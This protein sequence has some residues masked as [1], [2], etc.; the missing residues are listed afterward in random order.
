MFA[1]AIKCALRRRAVRAWWLSL[2]V[3][4]AGCDG[5]NAG[6]GGTASGGAGESVES[7]ALDGPFVEGAR[8][9]FSEVRSIRHPFGDVSGVAVGGDGD[10]YVGDRQAHVVWQFDSTG[11][12]VDSIGAEGDGP[13]D[14]QCISSVQ[15]VGNRL[16]VFD[17]CL[18]RLTSFDGN[19]PG[20]IR[21]T[22]FRTPQ[23]PNFA[24]IGGN[25]QV[26]A[27]A[28]AAY[29]AGS[30]VPTDSITVHLV[31]KEESSSR[32]GATPCSP[33]HGTNA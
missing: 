10:V 21:T 28:L 27:G 33:F 30:N 6:S 4:A 1:G 24:W 12:L 25:G 2:V 32:R 20:N 17:G 31:S 19:D 18:R 11:V 16:L 9:T 15:F 8:L 29:K 3:A 7:V 23:G 14:F 5:E 22:T 13:G 26:V